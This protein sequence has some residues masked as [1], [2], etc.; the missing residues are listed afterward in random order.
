MGFTSGR[1]PRDLYTTAEH[2]PRPTKLAHII[3]PAET[4][5]S[6]RT[7]NGRPIPFAENALQVTSTFSPIY[8]RGVMITD[9]Y[10]KEGCPF[11]IEMYA[12]NLDQ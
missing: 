2:V 4:C 6:N 8:S 5:K 12:Y 3:I 9:L 10:V 11:L 7:S 1:V